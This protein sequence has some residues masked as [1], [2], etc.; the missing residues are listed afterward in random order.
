MR[1]SWQVTGGC[2]YLGRHLY[3]WLLQLVREGERERGR[4]EK[5]GREAEGEGERG[6]GRGEKGTERGSKW[7]MKE[8]EKGWKKVTHILDV[9]FYIGILSPYRQRMSKFIRI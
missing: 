1:K 7:G 6:R 8:E 2:R 5:E 4:G 9:L 3:H